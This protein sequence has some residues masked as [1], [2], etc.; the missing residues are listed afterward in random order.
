MARTLRQRQLSD[1][2]RNGGGVVFGPNGA[3]T[4]DEWLRSNNNNP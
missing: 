2:Y 3:M 1:S 4:M